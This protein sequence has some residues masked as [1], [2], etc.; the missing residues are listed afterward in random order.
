MNARILKNDNSSVGWAQICDSTRAHPSKQ[1]FFLPLKNETCPVRYRAPTPPDCGSVVPSY[2]IDR[3]RSIVFTINYLLIFF[4]FSA[5]SFVSSLF[6]LDRVF[7]DRVLLLIRFFFVYLLV[8]SVGGSPKRGSLG[9]LFSLGSHHRPGGQDRR[10]GK[11]HRQQKKKKKI[12]GT[13]VSFR[14]TF[15]CAYH[16]LK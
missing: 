12:A 14:G 10:A 3:V 13:M 6:L 16:G 9:L 4:L 15:T 5:W 2:S 8:F 11:H 1:D 7:S